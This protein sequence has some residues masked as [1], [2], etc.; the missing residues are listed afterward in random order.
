MEKLT[1]VLARTGKATA[2][3]LTAIMK[4]DAAD[5]LNMLRELQEEGVV[6]RDGAHWCLPAEPGS[7]PDMPQFLPLMPE[8]LPVKPE[9]LPVSVTAT[10]ECTSVAPE[11][12]SSEPEST[13]AAPTANQTPLK[14]VWSAQEDIQEFPTMAWVRQRRRE[15]RN[16]MRWLSQIENIAR[17]I[18]RKKA[19]VE[20][21][22]DRV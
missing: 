21:F 19:A 6:N 9:N 10:P 16:E 11:S 20:Y 22:M 17:Q 12:T 13:S 18:S 5:A 14:V 7:L 1:D 15:L 2:R 8:I 3:E 4:I